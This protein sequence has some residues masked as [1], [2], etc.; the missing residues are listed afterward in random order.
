MD[1]AEAWDKLPK[2]GIEDLGLKGIM[3]V[4]KDHLGLYTD[5]HKDI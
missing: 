2:P 3:G 4:Y 1:N 5:I